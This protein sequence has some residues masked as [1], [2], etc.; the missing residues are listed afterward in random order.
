M[1]ALKLAEDRR[2]QYA[3]DVLQN[4]K[5]DGMPIVDTLPSG[6]TES[7]DNIHNYLYIDEK[8]VYDP[9]PEQPEP[10]PSGDSV[11]DELDTAYQAGYAEGYTEGVNSAYDQ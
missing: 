8:Y 5:Y 11:W 3:C 6:A 7:E 9:L 1:H 2:I 10:V 4:G